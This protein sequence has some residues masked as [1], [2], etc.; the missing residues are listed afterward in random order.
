MTSPKPLPHNVRSLLDAVRAKLRSYLLIKSVMMA[1]VWCMLIFWLGGGVDYLPTKLGAS[2]M[3][4]WARVFMLAA[5]GVG[6]AWCFLF[7]LLP[8]LWRKMPDRSLAVLVERL[9]SEFSNELVTVVDQ[10][11]PNHAT[12]SSG[13]DDAIDAEADSVSNPAAHAAMLDR[14]REVASEKAKTVE[15]GDLFNWQPIWALSV[16]LVVGCLFTMVVAFNS[17]AWIAFWCTRLFALSDETWPRS[18]ELRAD[19]LQLKFPAFTGQTAAERVTIPFVDSLA[20]LPFGSAPALNISANADDK[21]VPEVCTLYYSLEDGSRGRANMRRVGAA[22]DAWQLFTLDG[23]PLDGLNQDIGLSVL[24]LDARLR[25]LQIEVVEP[26]IISEMELRLKYPQYLRDEHSTRAE[27]ETLA[28]RSGMQVAEGTE[29]ALLGTASSGLQRVDYCVL[30][31]RSE[32]EVADPFEIQQAQIEDSHFTIPLGTIWENQVVEI[33][34]VDG[35]GLPSEQVFRYLVSMREDLVPEVESRLYGI[36]NAVT[37]KATLPI[38]GSVTDDNALAETS[39]ELVLNEGMTHRQPF[40][41]QNEEI[42]FDLDLVTLQ[43]ASQIRVEPGMT[44]GLVVAARDYY[45]LRGQSHVGRGQPKQLSVVTD[46]QLLV[47]LDRQELELRKRLELI[48]D[49]LGQLESALQQMEETAVQ[50]Q[51][52]KRKTDTQMHFVQ[53]GLRSS[54]DDDEGQQRRLLALKAQQSVLQCDK[55]EQE[56]VGVAERVN[57]LRMQLVNN[58]IDSYD[59]QERLEAKV[60]QPIIELLQNEYQ[61]LSEELVG[62]QSNQIANGRTVEIRA[63]QASLETVLTALRA[64]SGEYVGHRK[65]Q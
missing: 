57:D 31:D 52:S 34:L 35:Y 9:N 36:G 1:L 56:L 29:I 20:R 41:L 53:T 43:E 55:S 16:A 48:I 33:R 10:S 59:R 6:L 14:V 37:P 30:S 51:A 15:I 5:M 38:R 26:A 50:E 11:R 54:F 25:N 39:V 45:D 60:R 63:C 40:S 19:G 61:S 49:E 7:W 3:P 8:R 24:G 12:A 27:V 28:Y 47:I 2:E 17:P 62:L 22:R 21:L 13:P 4:H 42:S 23:P 64:I 44:L 32:E 18:A 65:L 58:R 46:D